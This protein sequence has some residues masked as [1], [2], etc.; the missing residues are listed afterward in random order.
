MQLERQAHMLPVGASRLEMRADFGLLAGR[1]ENGRR[2]VCVPDASTRYAD[3][4][5]GVKLHSPR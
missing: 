2:A 1:R 3:T 5:T 4:S